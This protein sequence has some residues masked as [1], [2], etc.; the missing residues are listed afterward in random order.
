MFEL[1]F[2]GT[3]SSAPSVQRGLS[4]HII[5]HRQYRFLLDCG[6]GTQRQILHSGLGFKRLNKVLLTHS[7]LDHILG[8]GGLISTLARWENLENIDIYGG[9]ATLKRV[10]DL[11][12]KVVFPGGHAP[13]DI[14]LIPLEPGVIM[15]DDK[16]ILSAFPVSHRG[17]DCFGFVFEEKE[18]RP[19]LD[20]QAAALG[21]PVGP[22][23]GRLVRGQTI[24]LSDGRTIHPDDVLGEA[25]P[26]VK[27]IHTGDVGRTDTL[28]EICRN[29]DTLVIESTYVEEEAEM[30]QQFGHMTAARAAT[31]ARNAGVKSLILTHLSR[32]YFE[33][34]VRR[35]AQAIFPNTAVARDFDHFQITR[36]GARRLPKTSS[37]EKEP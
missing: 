8:L 31:L 24:T 1:I 25:I 12:F 28:L 17:P 35:E 33:R 21:V 23:R 20:E 36:D 10:S 3:S 34:D 14:N 29:A 11:L 19:F 18:R 4:G 26:G 16:F 30:A 32:R 7:H 15:E 5:M 6:E 13:L 2:L 37:P 9:R 22:E 27:Y